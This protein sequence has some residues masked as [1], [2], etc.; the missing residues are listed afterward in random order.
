MVIWGEIRLADIGASGQV[1]LPGLQLLGF[2]RINLETAS[3]C[4][5]NFG[6][7]RRYSVWVAGR[8]I[9]SNEFGRV[10]QG[11][12]VRLIRNVSPEDRGTRGGVSPAEK[13]DGVIG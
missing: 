1:S 11:A 13:R 7:L 5:E 2:D 4:C 8:I 12:F 10:E 3:T 6:I 9:A